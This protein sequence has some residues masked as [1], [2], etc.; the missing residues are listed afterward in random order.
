MTDD[1]CRTCGGAARDRFC[2]S[3]DR[4]DSDCMC[5]TDDA[6]DEGAVA[7]GDGPKEMPDLGELV[8]DVGAATSAEAV[9]DILARYAPPSDRMEQEV[10]RERLIGVLTGTVK[11]PSKLVDAWL[12]RAVGEK[13][14]AALQAAQ[15]QRLVMLAT[16]NA[17]LFHDRHKEPYALVESGGHRETHRIGSRLFR[18]WLTKLYYDGN[19]PDATFAGGSAVP[20]AQPLRDALLQLE[21]L[22]VFGDDE[23]DVFVRVAAFGG[24]IYVDLADDDWRAVEITRDGWRVVS[25]PPVRFIRPEGTL[26]LPDPGRGGDV[27]A[28]RSFVNVGDKDWPLVAAWLVALFRPTGPYP[29]LEF[30]GEQ[31]SAKSTASRFC[32]RVIDPYSPLDRGRPRNEH[33]LV[34]AASRSWVISLDNLSGL[35]DWLSDGLCRLSTGGGFGAR[36]LYTDDEEKRFDATRPVTLN[37]IDAVA[38]RGDLLDRA[39]VITLPEIDDEDRRSEKELEAAFV[40]AWPRILGG[41]PDAAVVALKRID[42]V[43]LDR[44]PRM[45]DFAEWAVAAEPGLGLPKGRFMEAYTRNRE[46]A[47]ELTIESSPVGSELLAF[48]DGRELWEGTATELL[49]KLD[50]RVGEALRRERAW[51]KSGR[52]LSGHLRRLA[53]SLR[54][55]GLALDLDSRQPGGGRLVSVRRAASDRHDRHNRLSSDDAGEEVDGRDGHDRSRDGRDGSDGRLPTPSS[56]P[57]FASEREVVTVDGQPCVRCVKYGPDHEGAHTA[58]WAP[59]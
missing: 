35:P 24:Q 33:D 28:F 42:E 2:V 56:Q 14:E 18:R 21:G 58:S 5:S 22:A 43:K 4:L 26:P 48:M 10:A 41:L 44:R 53:P 40:K 17:V 39:L 7:D 6:F 13:E 31:G 29:V 15:A 57:P 52:G 30:L 1:R 9:A 46:E 51:P 59:A 8:S 36:A 47:N 34:I 12:K 20:G 16:E 19:L 32:R 37:G 45:A 23:S 11:R 38:T 27:S 55:V 49:G 50:A 25:D 3:C 54:R